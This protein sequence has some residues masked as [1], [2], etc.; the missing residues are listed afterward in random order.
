MGIVDALLSI[1]PVVGG[2][3]AGYLLMEAIKARWKPYKDLV[4]RILRRIER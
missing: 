2:A 1:A 4:A 3:V